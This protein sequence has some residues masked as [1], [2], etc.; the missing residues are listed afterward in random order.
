MG[1]LTIAFDTTIVGALALP[2]VVLIIHLFFFHGERSVVALLR[3]V[4]KQNQPAVAGVLLFAITYSLGSAIS[5]IAQDFFNDDDLH[6]EF[7]HRQEKSALLIRVGVTEY[8]ILASVYCDNQVLLHADG[9]PG[10]TGNDPLPHEIAAFSETSP[11]DFTCRHMLSWALLAPPDDGKYASAKDFEDDETS[12]YINAA[13]I[14]GLQE[15][16]LM[17]KG[18]DYTVRLRQLHDQVMVLRGAAFNGVLGFS[19]CLFAWGGQVRCRKPRS[20][21]RWGLAVIPGIYLG[22]TGLALMHHLSERGMSEPPFMEYTLLLLGLG[23]A[24]LVWWRS[25]GQ[26]KHGQNHEHRAGGGADASHAE[27]RVAGPADAARTS[28]SSLGSSSLGDSL[29]GSSLQD[30]AA[31]AKDA[32]TV[33]RT[34]K[35]Y[36]WYAE[37]WQRYAAVSLILTGAAIFGWWSTEVFYAEQVIYSYNSQGP[38]AAQK[39]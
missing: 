16:A 26:K 36:C 35:K 15:N 2:W 37:P 33:K 11:M 7:P 22:L 1:A 19:L 34:G 27:P 6:L 14:F 9:G 20:L 28:S 5:R 8:R 30:Q 31:N 38:G 18:Q 12:L 21:L 32:D 10:G 25:P 23:G 4:R 39:P 24:W 3:W 29:L 17:E 13:D